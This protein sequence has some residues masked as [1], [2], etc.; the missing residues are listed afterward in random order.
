MRLVFMPA[1]RRMVALIEGRSDLL[2]G[3]EMPRVLL[4]FCAH[5]AGW[6]VTLKQWE[7]G[8]YSRML[9]II[10]HPGAA[11]STYVADVFRALKADQRH[12]LQLATKSGRT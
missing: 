7:S 2:E 10:D 11:V 4:D 8:D 3:D 5:V 12:L 9:S 1:N 6:E